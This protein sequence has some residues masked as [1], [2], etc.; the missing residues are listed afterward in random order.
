MAE[1]RVNG[2]TLLFN[3]CQELNIHPTTFISASASGIYGLETSGGKTEEDKIG[4][5]WVA[6][7]VNDWEM[8]ADKFKQLGSRVIKMRISLLLSKTSGFLK[9]TLFSMRYGVG[10]IL[11]TKELPINW[12]HIND[13]AS[14]VDQAI[15]YDKYQGSYN[16]ANEKTIS[17]SM[18]IKTIRKK[19]FP[20]SIIITAPIYLIKLLLG[21][22]TLILNSNI[23]LSV[24]KLKKTGFLWQYNTLEDVLEN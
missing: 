4:S 16:L 12:I 20:Y 9:Y 24:E 17:N 18:I 7:M 19:I 6:K 11:G 13:A 23:I 15:K 14:F 8:A 5:D 21:K 1:S 10:I 3:K 22:R 2:A